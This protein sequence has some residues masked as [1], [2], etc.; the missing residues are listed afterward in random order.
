MSR[1][2]H[3]T[4][5]VKC[6]TFARTSAEAMYIGQ[7]T[8]D[9]LPR[10]WG[11][12]GDA[13]L[14]VYLEDGHTAWSSHDEFGQPSNLYTDKMF[15]GFESQ[16]NVLVTISGCLRDTT[17]DEAFRQTV[18]MLCRM[19][20]YIYVEHCVVMV[21]E[22]YGKTSIITDK[23]RWMCDLYEGFWADKDKKE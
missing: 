1:W 19:A 22:R 5:I 20:K 14:H 2:V 17:F 4:G 16:P 12:E 10:I 21:Q 11:S 18:A 15:H 9:H 8:I 7:T 13:N 23:N 3:I 6:D